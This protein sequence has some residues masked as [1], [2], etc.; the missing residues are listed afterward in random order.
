MDFLRHSHTGMFIEIGFDIWETSERLG[1]E[2]AETTLDTCSHLY[3]DKDP[4]LVEA[5]NK[6]CRIN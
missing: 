2:S 6:F 1:H 4:Q 5:L 3:P